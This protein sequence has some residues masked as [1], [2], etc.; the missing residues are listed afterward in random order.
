MLVSLVPPRH[1]MRVSMDNDASRSRSLQCAYNA[2]N[3][4]P[5]GRRVVI[6]YRAPPISS[7]AAGTSVILRA[8][9]LVFVSVKLV[10][11]PTTSDDLVLTIACLL[12]K[13]PVKL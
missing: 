7:L 11:L 5:P 6:L 9:L 10:F 12:G 1:G 3:H 4:L 8:G 2:I 13:T